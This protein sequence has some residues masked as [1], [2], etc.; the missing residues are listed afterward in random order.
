MWRFAVK[1]ANVENICHIPKCL[2]NG[3]D[4]ITAWIDNHTPSKLWDEITY[5]FTD[6]KG[7]T[8][9]IWEGISNFTFILIHSQTSKAWTVEIWEGIS[10]FTFIR[11][12]TYPC[13]F[14]NYSLVVIVACFEE[15]LPLSTLRHDDKKSDVAQAEVAKIPHTSPDGLSM[16]HLWR[17]FKRHMTARYRE[18]TVLR[19]IVGVLSCLKSIRFNIS[20]RHRD[21]FWPKSHLMYRILGVVLPNK[22]SVNFFLQ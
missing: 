16:R 12:L 4:P 10:N 17:V 13:W 3:L 22:N 14:L 8:V 20:L 11:Y 18:W 19:P 6:I 1:I 7:W 5:P 2:L 9:E 21:L 15:C